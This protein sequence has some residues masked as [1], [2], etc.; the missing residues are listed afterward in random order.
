MEASFTNLTQKLNGVPPCNINY[1]TNLIDDISRK[2]CCFRRACKH[3]DRDTNSTKVA[4][5]I[6]FAGTVDGKLPYP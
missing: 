5:S 4:T 1:E 6:I 3:P 2:K